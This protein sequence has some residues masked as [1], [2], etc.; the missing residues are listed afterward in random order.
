MR[1]ALNIVLLALIAITTCLA[2][3]EGGRVRGQ[4]WSRPFIED[5][6]AFGRAT[7]PGCEV[8]FRS[9]DVERKAVTDKEGNYESD[10]PRVLQ[11]L[12]EMRDRCAN[13]EYHPASR[14]EFEVKS[15]SSPMVNLMV[16]I[17]RIRKSLWAALPCR[18]TTREI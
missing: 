1:F 13:W 6:N 18:S 4:V 3:S 7:L 8:N 17:K 11:R 15:N 12:G 10:L 16:L 14:A 9:K 2:Q 5:T